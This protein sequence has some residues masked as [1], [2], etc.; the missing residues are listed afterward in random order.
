MRKKER[1][2]LITKIKSISTK[3]YITDKINKWK[4]FYMFLVDKINVVNNLK[5][6]KVNRWLLK[7][8]QKKHLL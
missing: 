3:T 7:K 6:L 2:F 8:T 4:F 5:L 1:I